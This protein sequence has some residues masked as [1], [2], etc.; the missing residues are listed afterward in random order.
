[1]REILFRGKT[2]CDGDWVYGGITWNP[3]RKKFFIHTDWEEANV[4]PETVGQYTGLTDKSGLTKVFEGDII[5]YVEIDVDGSESTHIGVFYYDA[6]KATWA[7]KNGGYRVLF[8]NLL[9][10]NIEAI[11]NIYDNPELYN[12][13]IRRL[14]QL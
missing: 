8:S 11:G 3:S 6:E 2:V 14:K 13:V 9:L 5:R 7:I 10:E 1:M 12:A 4:I